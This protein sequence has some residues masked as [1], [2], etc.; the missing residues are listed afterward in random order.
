MCNKPEVEGVDYE[1]CDH[2][3]E[4]EQCGHLY[5]VWDSQER[6]VHN[7]W[8]HECKM[9]HAYKCHYCGELFEDVSGYALTQ[10]DADDGS[11]YYI[12]YDC[13]LKEHGRGR[14]RLFMWDYI[15]DM[16]LT[17][18]NKTHIDFYVFE[19]AMG[20]NQLL[21]LW[22]SFCLRYGFV[23]DTSAYDREFMVLY[24][25]LHGKFPNVFTWRPDYLDEDEKSMFDHFD[26]FM[27]QYLV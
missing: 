13:L 11:Q 15:R 5:A 7:Y 16:E 9:Y 1:L 10:G 12:C 20:L 23:P 4:K 22:T 24:S 19:Q 3:G 8:C 26:L 2:C 17:E 6:E 14:D 18:A 25:K 21:C 27:G